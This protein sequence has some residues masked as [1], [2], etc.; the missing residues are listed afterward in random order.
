MMDGCSTRASSA[1]RTS[2]A[3]HSGPNRRP[4]RRRGASSPP[5]PH[6][7]S[8]RRSHLTGR[9]SRSHGER[10]SRRMCS[11]CQSRAALPGGLRSCPLPQAGR[12]GRPTARPWPSA[13]ERKTPW[14]YGA[15]TPRAARL[16]RFQRRAARRRA[17]KSRSRGRRAARSFISARATTTTTSSDPIAK[18]ERPLLTDADAAAG[19]LFNPRSSPDGTRL[20]LSWNR[21]PVKQG[22]GTWLAPFTPGAPIG[23]PQRVQ[24]GLT[25][26]LDWSA[27]GQ[28]LY[29]YEHAPNPRVMAVPV[30]GGSPIVLRELTGQRIGLLPSISPD[31]KTIVY[32]AHAINSDIWL[33]EPPVAG[34]R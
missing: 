3:R 7:I 32:S 12:P 8:F 28:L 30:A 16:K 13:L 9:W 4:R 33:A 17:R 31:K 27:D 10:A 23:H 25:W 24:A 19:W 15:S 22:L 14:S 11:C 5:A 1:T 29:L 21:S 34:R 2:G 18:Q 26:P 20:A 6:T